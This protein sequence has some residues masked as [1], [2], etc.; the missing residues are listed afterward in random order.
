M[1]GCTQ[2]QEQQGYKTEP[3]REEGAEEVRLFNLAK[4][5][6]TR[7]YS[8]GLNGALHITL[9][10]QLSG[11]NICSKSFI[12]IGIIIATTPIAIGMG[13]LCIGF[14]QVIK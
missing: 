10:G 9:R 2:T 4:I 12:I 13:E 11:S 14:T 7:N 3:N 1:P 6:P 8:I 5:R